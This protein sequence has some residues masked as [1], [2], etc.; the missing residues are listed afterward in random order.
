MPQYDYQCSQCGTVFEV[1]H[2]MAEKPKVKCP[3]CGSTRTA[4]VF[5]PAGVQFKGSGFYVTDSRTSDQKLGGGRDI[6]PKSDKP[7]SSAPDAAAPAGDSSATTPAPPPASSD[8]QV[9]GRKP[10]SKPAK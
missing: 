1:E 2:G 5:N 8:K 7:D 10:D 9:K 4:K 3:Q 6:T